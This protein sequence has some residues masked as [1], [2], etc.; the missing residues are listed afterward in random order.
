[1]VT[2]SCPLDPTASLPLRS[3][4]A[5]LVPRGRSEVILVADPRAYGY[6]YNPPR[7]VSTP[8]IRQRD[9]PAAGLPSRIPL[10]FTTCK[11]E[12]FG[13]IKLGSRNASTLRTGKLF[14]LRIS[15]WTSRWARPTPSRYVG[16]L[17]F[18]VAPRG[19]FSCR[20]RGS[21]PPHFYITI[22]YL[23][24]SSGR[25]SRTGRGG[26]GLGDEC[27]PRGALVPSEY[28]PIRT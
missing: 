14:L 5:I 27:Q 16:G 26:V 23:A 15:R 12:Y 10:V 24:S 22:V 21:W 4:K 3:F 11:A 7:C 2:R 1:M 17:V 28:D 20:A 13:N 18:V 25:Q 8:T 19:C 9:L 6:T